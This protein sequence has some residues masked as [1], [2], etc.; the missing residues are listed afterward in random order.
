M[1]DAGVYGVYVKP[2]GD[3]M[4]SASTIT[5]S[6]Q[7]TVVL[8]IGND[9]KDLS[10][11]AGVWQ[12]NATVSGPEES[13]N[14]NYISFGFLTDSPQIL[15]EVGKETLLFTFEIDGN[16][17]E[18]KLMDNNQDPFA[19]FPNSLNTNPGNEMSIL[20]IGASPVGYYYYAGNY[21]DDDPKSCTVTVDTTNT[22][23]TDTTSN[24]GE[25]PTS[26]LDEIGEEF[27]FTLSPN[28]TS[29]WIKV[30]FSNKV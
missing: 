5:G 14:K 25:T 3:I 4:P 15:L 7:V 18:P 26:T 17:T 13:P 21:F 22:E 2:C 6:A 29:Q 19:V 30:D 28:P 16:A 10:L 11:Y 8:P 12:Q 23:T 20:D 1:P 24:N 9:I 27:Y